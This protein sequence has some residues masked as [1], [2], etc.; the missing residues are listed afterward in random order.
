MADNWMMAFAETMA[1]QDDP[2][3]AAADFVFDPIRFAQTAAEAEFLETINTYKDKA[4]FRVVVTLKRLFIFSA[5]IVTNSD[6]HIQF[7]VHPHDDA[8]L[9][10]LM[11]NRAAAKWVELSLLKPGSGELMM[12]LLFTNVRVVES[13]RFMGYKVYRAE[14]DGWHTLV[15]NIKEL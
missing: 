12:K 14:I 6:D 3:S 1:R 7:V 15:S 8:T 5:V 4:K 2:A 10:F 11:E 9:R 13:E